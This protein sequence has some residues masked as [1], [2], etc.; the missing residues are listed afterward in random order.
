MFTKAIVRRP[1]KSIIYG[2][3]SSPELGKPDYDLAIKQHD[4]YIE[5]LKHRGL[6]VTILEADEN[7]PDSCFV[8]DV[9]VL[10]KDFAVITN[11][12]APTRKG[13]VNG[14]TDVIRRF[15]PDSKIEYIRE[16]GTLEGGDVMMVGNHFYVGLSGRTNMEGIKQFGDILRKYGYK[17]TVVTLKEVLHLKTGVSYLENGNLLVAGEFIYKDEFKDFNRIIV[18]ENESYAAN[19]LWIN[20]KVLVPVGFEKTKNAI[21]KSGYEVIT[22]DTSEFRKLDGGLSCLSLRF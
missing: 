15:Y 13:E 20:D 12:G 7:Y 1:G 22:V 19:S 9:A 17:L 2:I 11:P 18:P 10:T 3:T 8:E 5:A 14:I 6:E 21:E 4:A 16:P